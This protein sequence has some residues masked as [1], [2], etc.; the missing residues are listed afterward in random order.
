MD[1]IAEYL[2]LTVKKYEDGNYEAYEALGDKRFESSR[3]A[4]IKNWIIS[5]LDALESECPEL[6]ES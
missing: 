5:Q 2:N 6:L 4:D 1:I 3:W